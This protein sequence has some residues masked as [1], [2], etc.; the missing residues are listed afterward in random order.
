M[1][2]PTPPW[3]PAPEFVIDLARSHSGRYRFDEPL[4]A[5]AAELVAAMRAEAPA[6]LPPGLVE[7]VTLRT[8]SRFNAEARHL[9]DALD[10]DW[11]DLL[12]ASLA[13][14]AIVSFFACS[15]VAAPSPRGPVL[16]R[17][18]DFW[19]ERELARASVLLRFHSDGR[20]AFT[21]AGWPGGIGLV[22]G[23]SARG[24]A[25]VL[26]AVTSTERVPATGYPVMLH[27]RR[28][29]ED[30][31]GFDDAVRRVTKQ[32]LGAPCLV[33]IVG[34]ENEQRVVVER[35]PTRSAHRWGEPGKPLIA[36]NDFRA[37]DES[38]AGPASLGDTTCGRFGCLS[39]YMDD[40]CEEKAASDA[41]LLYGL[42]GEGVLSSI[43][44]QHTIFR[45]REGLSSLYIPRRFLA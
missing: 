25:L 2:T 44:A 5:R 38:G 11:K 20:E 41:A 7:L 26:N 24:F 30:A 14:D 28:V 45:P 31:T 6:E 27:L 10:L 19:P 13:Y 17:N 29:V 21:L 4:R 35:T 1:P 18:M 3:V 39:G 8:A 34:T 33:T 9:A 36:T 43:T 32:T 42:S 23:S 40:R 15:T 12:L 22:S 37:L 16:A